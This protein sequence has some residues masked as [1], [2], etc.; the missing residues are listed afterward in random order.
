MNIPATTPYPS[1]VA[2]FVRLGRLL[3]HCLQIP[4]VRLDDSGVFNPG[5][6][7]LGSRDF[8]IMNGGFVDEADAAA[9]L[10]ARCIDACYLQAYSA[11]TT[12]NVVTCVLSAI[13]ATRVIALVKEKSGC[14]SA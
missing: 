4:I 11:Y 7:Y 2:D 8:A 9:D 1:T 6:G 12:P 14:A 3:S 10:A 13:E 5:Y